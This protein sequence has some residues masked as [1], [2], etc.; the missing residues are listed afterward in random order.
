MAKASILK[1]FTNS[2]SKSSKAVCYILLKITIFITEPEKTFIFS[3]CCVIDEATI[4]YTIV[5][6]SSL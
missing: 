2:P 6:F 3:L 4:H 5:M 1:S